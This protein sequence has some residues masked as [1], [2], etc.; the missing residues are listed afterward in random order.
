MGGFCGCWMVD[1][2]R[3]EEI[4]KFRDSPRVFSCWFE[5]EC[6]KEHGSGWVVLYDL[7]SLHWLEIFTEL[8]ATE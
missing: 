5:K 4:K 1:W 3:K 7:W 2:R 6:I 8:L